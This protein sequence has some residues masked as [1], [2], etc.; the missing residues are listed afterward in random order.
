MF[1]KAYQGWSLGEVG[2]YGLRDGGCQVTGRD[3]LHFAFLL[4]LG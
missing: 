1:Y 3:R 4:Y 2:L